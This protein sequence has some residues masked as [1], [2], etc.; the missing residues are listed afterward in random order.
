VK[1]LPDGGFVAL[2]AS[3]DLLDASSGASPGSTLVRRLAPDLSERWRVVVPGFSAD[4]ITSAGD[5]AVVRGAPDSIYARPARVVRVSADGATVTTVYDCVECALDVVEGDAQGR[6]LVVSHGDRGRAQF[7]ASP[8][9]SQVP[10][11]PGFVATAGG[12]DG[13]GSAVLL[14]S[15]DPTSSGDPCVPGER[16]LV[17]LGLADGSRAW[18]FPFG[19]PDILVG[20]VGFSAAG[21]V[22]L[23]GTSRT[24]VLGTFGGDPIPD[25]CVYLF[26]VEANG[27]PRWVRPLQSGMF[28]GIDAWTLAV[29]PAGKALLVQNDTSALRPPTVQLWNPAGDR[30]WTRTWNLGADGRIANARA[31]AAT[32]TDAFMT[33]QMWGTIDLGSGPVSTPASGFSTGVLLD[34]V[35]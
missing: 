23:V 8:D 27:S 12:L 1:R 11:A 15:A 31:L 25:A 10:L 17:K 9:G 35:P 32:D 33:F 4:G 21:T 6:V 34:L 26:T 13:Q 22:V 18:T 19:L 20:D 24:R 5:G 30:L 16:C 3:G 2:L 14:G 29:Q 7:V 28:C